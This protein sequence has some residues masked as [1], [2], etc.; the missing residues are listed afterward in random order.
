MT[1]LKTNNPKDRIG[2]TK[3]PLTLLPPTPQ[4][5][6]AMA[7]L[8]GLLKYG[9]WNWRKEKVA[10]SVYLDACRR[11]IEDWNDREECAEDSGVHHL[12]HACACLFIIMDAQQCGNMIDDRAEVPGYC[13]KLFT[14]LSEKVKT[15]YEARGE[16]FPDTPPINNEE[17]ENWDD[18]QLPD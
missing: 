4:A 13:S 2:V 11:H 9:R 16:S 6:T 7:L 14:E 3:V 10:A 17:K 18:A 12:G 8:D 1:I 15:L 5:H